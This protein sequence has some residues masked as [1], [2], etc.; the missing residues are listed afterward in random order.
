MVDGHGFDPACSS[1]VI[2]AA[3]VP[4]TPVTCSLN[5][6]TCILGDAQTE[7]AKTISHRGLDLRVWDFNNQWAPANGNYD[8]VYVQSNAAEGLDKH[9]DDTYAQEVRS[10]LPLG[11]LPALTSMMGYIAYR[12]FRA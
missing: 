7:P 10:L 8:G 4:C 9:F 5:Q 3:G 2:Y 11:S 12:L 1:N 6:V